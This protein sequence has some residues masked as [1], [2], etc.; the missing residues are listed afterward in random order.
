MGPILY[1]KQHISSTNTPKTTIFHLSST[2]SLNAQG[3]KSGVEG[4]SS[5]ILTTKT[6]QRQGHY[7]RGTI[8]PL[9]TYLREDCI[10][11][12]AP[13]F[14]PHTSFPLLSSHIGKAI[15]SQTTNTSQYKNYNKY[16]I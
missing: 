4:N 2:K 9:T 14:L 15:Y 6:L 13:P 5:L 3:T 12:P 16:L 10:H 7:M 1:T 11:V 8:A